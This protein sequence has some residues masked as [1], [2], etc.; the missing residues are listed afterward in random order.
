MAQKKS[1]IVCHAIVEDLLDIQESLKVW[2][3]EEFQGRHPDIGPIASCSLLD[4][5]YFEKF[6]WT[7]QMEN[8]ECPLIFHW[9]FGM[10]FFISFLS[11]FFARIQQRT[12]SNRSDIINVSTLP[13]AKIHLC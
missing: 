13:P 2:M 11:K 6:H 12:R 3:K 7:I 5:I 4:S 10:E 9:P 1:I 8:V